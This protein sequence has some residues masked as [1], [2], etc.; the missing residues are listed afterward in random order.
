MLTAAETAL[1]EERGYLVFP[2]LIAGARLAHYLAIFD[3][4][5][6]RGRALTENVSHFA[7]EKNAEGEV[8]PGLLHKVQGVCAAVPAVLDLAREPAVVDRAAA[9]IGEERDAFGT[10]FFPKLPDGGTSTDWH[11]DTYY[12][13][14]KSAQIISCG[15]YLQDSDRENGCLRVIPGTHR[16]GTIAT[17]T[18][19]QSGYGAWVSPDESA[20]V[21]VVVP[22]G[23]VVLFSANLMHG[24]HPNTSRR[25]RYS[26]AWHY[27]PAA[28]ELERFPRGPAGERH[29]VRGAA[30]V[31]VAG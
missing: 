11:Q 20:A 23:S 4:I 28:L 16:T 29:V 12:F 25:S 24:A 27:V 21:D 8:I 26:T 15:I 31:A 17:H 19:R 5:V 9:L 10:K 30:A 3:D 7:L 2:E 18:P 22:A 6:A 13:G 14:S 1:F